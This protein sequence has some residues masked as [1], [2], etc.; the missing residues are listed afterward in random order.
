LWNLQPGWRKEVM[1]RSISIGN[2]L[3]REEESWTLLL[4]S[5]DL[6][7]LCEKDALVIYLSFSYRFEFSLKEKVPLPIGLIQHATLMENSK[8]QTKWTHLAG[9]NNES[10][11][12][13]IQYEIGIRLQ[14]G[15]FKSSLSE[16]VWWDI[17]QI[18]LWVTWRN[19]LQGLSVFKRKFKRITRWNEHK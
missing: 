7:K 17:W 13:K 3:K 2:R 18:I 14:R 5:S 9:M 16:V 8:L 12:F 11:L 19:T 15:N 10:P 1:V 6:R 4:A